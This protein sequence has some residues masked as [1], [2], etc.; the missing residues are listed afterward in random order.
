MANVEDVLYEAH[1]LG[2]YKEVMKESKKLQKKKPH[3]EV[4]DRMDK[5]LHIVINKN[6]N[7]INGIS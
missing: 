6:K 3:M 2:I 4:A 1:K 7:K 5:A